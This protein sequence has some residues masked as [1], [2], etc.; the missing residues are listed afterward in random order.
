MPP[1]LF[2]INSIVLKKHFSKRIYHF[3]V[4]LKT[5][6]YFTT[7]IFL[8]CMLENYLSRIVQIIIVQNMYIKTDRLKTKKRMRINHIRFGSLGY[9]AG[10]NL[11]PFG[12]EHSSS[13]AC[14]S[15]CSLAKNL[16][17]ATFINASPS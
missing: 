12:L 13:P 10:S 9:G 3:V 2:F 17:L 15:L 1:K 5:A 6:I 11:Q 7:N 14:H 16:P 4:F 8:K